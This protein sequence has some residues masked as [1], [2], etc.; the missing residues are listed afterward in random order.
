M[1]VDRGNINRLTK[2]MKKYQPFAKLKEVLPAHKPMQNTTFNFAQPHP[3]PTHH[4]D[5]SKQARKQFNSIKN[6]KNNYLCN[7]E[8]D[9]YF[10]QHRN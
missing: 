1:Q 3:K 10:W 2:K 7:Y 5:I 8:S 4:P 6:V 9:G